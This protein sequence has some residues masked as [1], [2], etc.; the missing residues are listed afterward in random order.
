MAAAL[1]SPAL[2]VWRGGV[3]AWE[4]DEMGHLNVRFHLAR[5]VEGLAGVS[6]ALGLPGAFTAQAAVTLI[7]REH[8]ARFHRE[9]HPGMALHMT[10][11]VVEMG[12]CDAQILQRLIN[13]TSGE[14]CATF[15][16]RV[17]LVSTGDRASSAW[18]ATARDLGR[19][20]ACEITPEAAPRG[21]PGGPIH[22]EA[23]RAQAD[24][25]GMIA[26]GRGAVQ[27][28][29]CDVFGR[30]RPEILIGRINA[31]FPHLVRPLR[32]AVAQALDLH[33][34]VGGAALEYR[35]IY[36]DHAPAG[37]P[38]ELRSGLA[39]LDAKRMR[40]NHWLLDPVTGAAVATAENV[41]VNLDLKLRSTIALPP[42]IEAAMQGH[43]IGGLSM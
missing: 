1:T 33:G 21:V 14:V 10:A 29:D 27:T 35:L 43:V 11:G 31:G 2:E 19:G 20:L 9:C 34:R 4:C 39:A 38:F 42:D 17:A 3:S 40:M 5:A 16:T 32:E 7:V 8:H 12:E 37:A 26:L 15:L 41:S 28:Q 23:S 24:A 36:F 30:M 22:S 25:L 18:P 13:S 6:Q